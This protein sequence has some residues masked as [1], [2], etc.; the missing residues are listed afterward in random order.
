MARLLHGDLRQRIRAL[1]ACQAC[2]DRALILE[3]ATML[4]ALPDPWSRRVALGLV[5]GHRLVELF[6]RALELLRDDS[7]AEFA[8]ETL[9]DLGDPRAVLPL[10]EAFAGDRLDLKRGAALAL[11]KLDVAGCREGFLEACRGRLG[12]ADPMLRA[13]ALREAGQL[14]HADAIPVLVLGLSDDDRR[15]RLAAVRSLGRLD[16]ERIRAPLQE[17]AQDPDDEV[18]STAARTLEALGRPPVEIDP[19]F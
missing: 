1:E 7:L 11:E 3:A 5:K 9:G 2:S 13:Q 4:I 17:A 19:L 8:A 15:V 16:D 18:K 12:S 14:V 6:P 10:M